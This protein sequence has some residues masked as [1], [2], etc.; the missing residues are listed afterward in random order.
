MNRSES[1]VK[2]IVSSRLKE[3]TTDETDVQT[4][5]KLQTSQS[6]WNQIKNG[7]HPPTLDTLILISKTYHV[8][9]DWLLGLKDEK[10]INVVNIDALDYR[11]VFMVLNK[12][13]EYKSIV[14]AQST[15]QIVSTE[16]DDNSEHKSE[17]SVKTK[18]VDY[19]LLRINDPVLSFMLRRRMKLTEVDPSY[20]H[21]WEEKHLPEYKDLA[22]SEC[23]EEMKNYFDKHLTGK[24]DGDLLTCLAEYINMKKKGDSD[25]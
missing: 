5:G 11:Q 20:F 8:S 22:L 1:E 7:I 19:D 9:V 2:K 6:N 12:L 3:L 23:N 14:P 16:G 4:A 15:E 17:P 13:Q 24:S 25:E 18:G 10:D 21:D